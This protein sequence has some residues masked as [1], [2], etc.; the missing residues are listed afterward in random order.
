MVTA[1]HSAVDLQTSVCPPLQCVALFPT[2]QV[3]LAKKCIIVS[4]TGSESP[5]H[6]Q[7]SVIPSLDNAS[8]ART[9]CHLVGLH[10]GMPTF[11]N[12]GM[13]TFSNSGMPTFSN[14]GMPTFSNSGMP[15][16]SNSGMPMFSNS[17]R[18]G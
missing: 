6:Q 4:P 13:P 11:S 1:A 8:L 2:R 10:W 9:V 5:T 16:F 18:T 17:G 15:T 3:G 7:G 12:S 14:S